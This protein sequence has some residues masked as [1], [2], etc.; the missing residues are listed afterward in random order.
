MIIFVFWLKLFWGLFLMVKL[1]INQH[2]PLP[3]PMPMTALSTE[4]YMCHQFPINL[5]PFRLH[6]ECLWHD[7]VIKWKQ[8]PRNW[9]FVWGIHRSPVN[10][11][12]KGQW[13][14]ALMFS[15]ICVWIND[16]VNN[17]ET[18]DL[19]RYRA[20]YDVIVMKS[21]TNL[22]SSPP[23]L[24]SPPPP[25]PTTTA[26][27]INNQHQHRHHRRQLQRQ[28]PSTT[29]TN[30]VTTA[31]NYNGSHHQQPAPTSSP[32]PPTTTAVTINNQHQHRHHRRQLQRQSPST[33]STNIVTTAAN[34]NGSH[35]QQPAPTSSPPPPLSTIIPPATIV[36]VTIIISTPIIAIRES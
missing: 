3:E 7:D 6:C 5:S 15:L 28:S 29:S 21:Y 33:T 4:A 13:L 22:D 8:F 27:T 23:P 1:A 19:R 2:M 9:P 17:R 32:P 30:I 10:S 35:H 25:P 16:W 26:V 11:P 12:H 36:I 31:A 14:G 20:H 34:Y 24:P 18:G